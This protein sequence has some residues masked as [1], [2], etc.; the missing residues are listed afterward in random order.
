MLDARCHDKSHGVELCGASAATGAKIASFGGSTRVS[1]ECLSRSRKNR[2]LPP[3]P[4]YC[5]SEEF[6]RLILA[7]IKQGRTRINRDPPG[8]S[9]RFASVGS[10]I[11]WRKRG[12]VPRF[13]RLRYN[14]LSTSI[15][16]VGADV[17]APNGIA[18][19][20]KNSPQIAL[21][22]DRGHR[23]TVS[24]RELVDFVRTQPPIEW[25]LF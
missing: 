23:F 12:L 2:F 11:A 7:Q 10:R 3:T 14:P 25:V 22:A 24:G 6:V 20:I 8:S 4:F 5:G 1:A 9:R 16:G 18:L 17:D 19:N 21:H 13:A 15:N